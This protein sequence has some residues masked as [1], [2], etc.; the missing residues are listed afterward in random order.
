LKNLSESNRERGNVTPTNMSAFDKPSAIFSAVVL[1]FAGTG[2]A[3]G[4]PL[5]V[6][7]MAESLGFSDQQLG[8]LA[9]SD[10]A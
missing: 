2:V 8:W 7:S 10:M 1:G 3:M 5:L 9:S 4:L 6:G